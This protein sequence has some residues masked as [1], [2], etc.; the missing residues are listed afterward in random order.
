MADA[1]GVTP[2][3]EE[4]LRRGN[5]DAVNAALTDG[6]FLETTLLWFYVLKEAEVRPTATP[7][8]RSAAGSWSRP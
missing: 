4:E 3:A 7:W 6:G 1:L 2:L 5:G 8:A